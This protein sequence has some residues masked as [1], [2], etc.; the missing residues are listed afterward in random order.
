MEKE[1]VTIFG[2]TGLLGGAIYRVLDKDKYTISAPSRKEEFN[3][4][5]KES[6]ENYFKENKPKYI[7]M[8]AG[9]V[10]GIKANKQRGADFLYQN[11]M[12]IF[13]VLE[14][15]RKYSPNSKILYTGSTC[16][17]PKENPQP[18]N[19]E[20]FLAGK[21][22]QTNIGYAISKISGIVACQ[23][24]KEQYGIN[25]VCVMPINL[26]GIGDNYDLEEGHFLAALIKKCYDSKMSGK[27]LQFWGTGKPRREALYSEDCAKACIYVV[28]NYN[29]DEIINIGTGFDYSIKE[30][31]E[32]MGR[33]MKL[34]ISSISWDTTKPDGTFEKRTDI[35]RLKSIMPEF[36][37]RSFEDGVKEVLKGDFNYLFR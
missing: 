20:R 21:L 16:I 7:F 4:L 14:A 1:L 28:E 26:Y 10:G 25:S 36:N 27:A 18:I 29:G 23:L 35:T 37:P 17:Y 31:V 8:V 22:E 19:E 13:N 6:V 2:G 3:L 12:M 5:S 24:Y 34:D 32:I 15:V 30:Y 33:L 11:S 9:L